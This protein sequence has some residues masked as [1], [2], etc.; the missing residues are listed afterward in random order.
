MKAYEPA[1]SRDRNRDDKSSSSRPAR[2]TAKGPI[3][4]AQ[5]F[6][7][8]RDPKHGRRKSVVE[9]MIAVPTALMLDAQAVAAPQQPQAQAS[10]VA[11]SHAPV[12]MSPQMALE[13][14]VSAA[15]L[16]EIEESMKELQIELEPAHL[17]PLVVTV[18]LKEG[19]LVTRLTAKRKEAAEVL[20]AGEKDLEKRLKSV[21]SRVI[22][23]AVIHDE[24][25]ELHQ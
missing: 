10:Q 25:L 19:K 20:A 4:F 13:A 12:R 15:R 2:R 17:G 5:V 24:E 9:E 18:K 22:D 1:G 3:G 8:V 14:T 16:A 6:S 11:E 21:S 7:M 23:L